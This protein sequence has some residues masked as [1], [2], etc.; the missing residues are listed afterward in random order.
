MLLKGSSYLCRLIAV[1]SGD[2][3][4][5]DALARAAG[6]LCAAGRQHRPCAGVQHRWPLV[7]IPDGLASEV[8]EL[9][10]YGGF[11]CR[12]VIRESRPLPPSGN[13]SCTTRRTAATARGRGLGRC[14]QAPHPICVCS[15]YRFR[16]G[17]S[18]ADRQ[19]SERN[20]SWSRQ[21]PLLELSTKV[22]WLYLDR[23]EFFRGK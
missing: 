14:R 20:D 21:R 12:P 19:C 9:S 6:G 2:M 16:I 8:D 13:P 3:A 18:R 23:V 10:E 1:A 15:A 11:N 4:V 22:A 5:W 7:E 17:A